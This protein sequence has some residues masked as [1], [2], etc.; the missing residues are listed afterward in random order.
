MYKRQAGGAVGRFKAGALGPNFRLIESCARR[1]ESLAAG[2]FA[3]RIARSNGASVMRDVMRI[4]AR[5][6]GQTDYQPLRC[7]FSVG[8]EAGSIGKC[9]LLDTLN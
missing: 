5:D 4:G 8:C 7:L 1:M 2:Q 9:Q 3:P 6:L